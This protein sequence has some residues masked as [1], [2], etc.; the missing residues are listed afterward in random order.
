M[1]L[2]Q[3]ADKL[4]E[5]ESAVKAKVLAVANNPEG[6]YKLR[7]N[8]YHHYGFKVDKE[9]DHH[10]L[11]NSELAFLRWEIERGVLNAED[12]PTQPG[13]PWWRSVNLDF[14]Y[15]AELA[16]A[17]HEANIKPEGLPATVQSWLEYIRDPKEQTW[18]R[19]HNNSIVTGYKDYIELAKKESLGEKLFLNEVLYRVLYAQAMV[20][21]TPEGLGPLGEVLANPRLPSVNVMVHMADF[22]P[23]HY[24]LTTEDV[25]HIRHK[26]HTLQEAAV[27]FLDDLIILPRLNK[28]YHHCAD[29]LKAEFILNWRKLNA[30]V[31]PDLHNKTGVWGYIHHYLLAPFRVLSKAVVGIITAP[32]R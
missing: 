9:G 25:K 20:E 26:G 21:N 24:P 1:A 12:H 28:L 13:S 31:Y 2:I 17:I 10:G 27:E 30:P 15:N 6:R 14:I 18:Y 23:R 22:Y 32:F 8:F 5:L 19:A 4:K 3:T 16:R 7:E 11:G 29:W